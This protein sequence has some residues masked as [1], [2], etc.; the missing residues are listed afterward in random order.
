MSSESLDIAIVGCGYTG[1]S[2]LH[3]LA[4]QYRPNSVTVF[5]K[6]GVWGPGYPYAVDESPNYLLNNAANT[7]G[8]SPDDRTDFL[9]WLESREDLIENVDP[10]GHYPRA[11]FGA[12]LEQR[13]QEAVSAL[14]AAGI[15]VVLVPEEVI[16]VDEAND[17]SAVLHTDNQS[18]SANVV[19]LSTG[20]CPD[21][22]KLPAEALNGSN[23]VYSTHIPAHNLTALDKH[24]EIHILGASLSALD[25]INHVCADNKRGS[26]YRDENQ[27]LQFLPSDVDFKL[28]LWSR[29]GRF[30]KIQSVAPVVPTR[31]AFTREAISRLAEDG[32]V[33]LADLASLVAADVSANGETIH[34]PTVLKPYENAEDGD[35]V[36]AVVESIIQKELEHISRND[37]GGDHWLV[38]FVDDALFVLWDVFAKR[39]LAASAEEKYRKDYET[40]MLAYLAPCPADTAERVTALIRSGSLRVIRNAIPPVFDAKDECVQLRS[41][42]L[43]LNAHAVV[44]ATGGVSRIVSDDVQTRLYKHLYATGL[45]KQYGRDGRKMPGIEVD[46]TSFRLG[47]SSSVYLASHFLWGPGLFVS[48]AFYMA[49]IVQT[50]LQN[51]FGT[52]TVAFGGR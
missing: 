24:S 29:S 18:F 25:V 35:D 34:W 4:A 28:Y 21:V 45:A 48:S 1:T 31:T 22:T 44:D 43:T 13:F 6:S 5:E 26:F 20:R 9:Y 14:R 23:A 51:A 15:E 38:D 41:K 30:K 47:S 2:A 19:I 49:T 11:Y 39:A 8:I 17:E 50:I 16:R 46:M 7:L 3:Q 37:Q 32:N 27:I 40:T 52:E 42:S 10:V 33:S 12:Y 36:S